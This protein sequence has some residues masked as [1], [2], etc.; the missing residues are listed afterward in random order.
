MIRVY[1]SQLKKI[2]QLAI[3]TQTQ[4]FFLKTL[5]ILRHAAA[6][7]RAHF[8]FHHFITYNIKKTCT[9]DGD[10]IKLI[11]YTALTKIFFGKIGF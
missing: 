10:L 1:I 6:M 2:V 7:S 5:T 3:H 4:A 9:Q 8:L 11:I